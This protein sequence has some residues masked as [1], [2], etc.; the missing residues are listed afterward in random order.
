LA[1]LDVSSLQ[2]SDLLSLQVD[3]FEEFRARKITRTDN[4]PT[5]DLSEFIFCK[6]FGWE[7]ADNSQKGYDAIS[8][9]QD[10]IQIKGRRCNNHN[11]SRQLSAIRDLGSFDTLAAILYKHDYTIMRA[12]LI[13]AEMVKDYA[14]YQNHTNSYIFMLRDSIFDDCRVEDVTNRLAKTMREL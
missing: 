9:T 6:T 13:P 1:D 5:G 3:I 8:N 4:I 2:L 11:K 12:A 10:R 14:R 7:I